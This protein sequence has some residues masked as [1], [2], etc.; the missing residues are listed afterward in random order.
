MR[1]R[2]DEALYQQLQKFAL[3]RS[4]VRIYPNP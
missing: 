2:I 3:S 4:Q 1:A